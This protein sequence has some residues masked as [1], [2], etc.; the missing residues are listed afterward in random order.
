MQQSTGKPLPPSLQRYVD[1]RDSKTNNNQNQKKNKP[2]K[3]GNK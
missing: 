2:N 1:A 3:K